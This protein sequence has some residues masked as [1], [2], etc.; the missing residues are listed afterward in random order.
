MEKI[1]AVG[2]G[3]RFF[4]R[5]QKRYLQKDKLFFKK[6]YLFFAECAIIRCIPVGYALT[7]AFLHGQKVRDERKNYRNVKK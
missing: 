6:V 7:G 1:L 4:L 5:G 3:G 2:R